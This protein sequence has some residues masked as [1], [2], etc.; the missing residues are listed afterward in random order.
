MNSGEQYPD[1]VIR[2]DNL[3]LINQLFSNYSKVRIFGKGPTFRDVIDSDDKTLHIGVNQ[4][5]NYLTKCDG[6]VVNDI[7][8]IYNV[9]DDFYKRLK[10]II[11][12]EYP[13][14]NF[15][16]NKNTTWRILWDK[17]N[18][19]FNGH[20]IIYN[21]KTNKNPNPNLITLKS[22][23]FTPNTANDF[24]VQYLNKYVTEIEYYGIAII[25][26][27]EYNPIFNI[28]SVVNMY[29]NSRLIQIRD[30]LINR[31]KEYNISYSFN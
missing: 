3:E 10:F 19:I 20:I 13:H 31:C 8:H 17:I 4:T 15:V 12:P 27:S 29:P 26:N 11:I 23:L 28:K 5:V 6:L 18:D 2:L 24:V 21:L 14:K 9:Q 30:N 1:C 16:F 22:L 25:D 7:E